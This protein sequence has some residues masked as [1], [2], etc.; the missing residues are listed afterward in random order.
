MK[1]T[2]F[3]SSTICEDGKSFAKGPVG[4]PS[5]MAPELLFLGRCQLFHTTPM[6]QAWPRHG[7][8]H[9]FPVDDWSLGISLFVMLHGHYP[10]KECMG[11]S[12][13]MQG[14]ARYISAKQYDMT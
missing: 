14:H 10:W 13:D 5:Y 3:G 7:G 4:T 8:L 11:V 9:G 2:D 6:A 1:I 12:W